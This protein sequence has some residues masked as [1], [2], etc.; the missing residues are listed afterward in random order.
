MELR[1]LSEIFNEMKILI[2]K[3]HIKYFIQNR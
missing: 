1:I 3:K 2:N